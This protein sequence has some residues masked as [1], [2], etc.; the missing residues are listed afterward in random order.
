MNWLDEE[1]QRRDAGQRRPL[2]Q[3]Q[4]ELINSRYPGCTLERC[5]ECDDPTGRAGRGDDSL[6]TDEGDGPYCYDCWQGIISN[7]RLDRT[8]T[9]GK[10]D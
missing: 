6:Y 1:R 3:S 8:G 4:H 7:A 10:E 5:C 2:L 9:A